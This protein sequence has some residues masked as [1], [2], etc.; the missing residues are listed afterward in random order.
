MLQSTVLVMAR[1]RFIAALLG[2]LI[3]LSGRTVAFKSDDEGSDSAVRRTHPDLV[4][5]DCALGIPACSEIAAIARVEGLRLLLFSA[6]HTDREARDIASLYGAQFFVLPI[7][8]REFMDSLDRA[9]GT[10]I[11]S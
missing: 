9:I 10:T 6:S 3:E 7:K 8:P 4:M 11:P 5:F 2:G 1:D